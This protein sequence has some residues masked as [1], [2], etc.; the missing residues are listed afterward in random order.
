MRWGSNEPPSWPPPSRARAWR[1]FA[2]VGH[3]PHLEDPQAFLRLADP[4][5]RP[6][7]PFRHHP[8][9]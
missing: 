9:H 1:S 4:F 5:L 7:D 3:T 2:G 8:N 6:A